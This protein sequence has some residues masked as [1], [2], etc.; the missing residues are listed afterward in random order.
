MF[1]LQGLYSMIAHLPGK[2]KSPASR[3]LVNRSKDGVVYKQCVRVYCACVL[4]TC[5]IP[6]SK[7]TRRDVD[8]VVGSGCV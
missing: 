1:K 6:K 7:Q 4:I 3:L 2:T 5:S 8:D